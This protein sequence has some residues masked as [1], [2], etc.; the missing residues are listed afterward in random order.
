MVRT[1]LIRNRRILLSTMLGVAGGVVPRSS[2]FRHHV[3]RDAWTVAKRFGAGSVVNIERREIPF[4]VDAVI[5]G[6]VEDHQAMLIAALARGLSARTFFEIGTNRGRTSWTV[7]HNN[8]ELHVYTLDVPLGATSANV[9]LELGSD[10]HRFFRPGEAC[11]E[12]FRD[13][14]E[15]QRITQLWGDSATFDFSP[16]AGAIDLIYVDGGHSYAY[17]KSDT[18]NALEVL[19]PTGAI[20][21]DD[22]GSHPG[23]YE[24]VTELAPTLDKP[25][26]HVF[27]SRMAIY[28]RRDFVVRRP[29]DDHASLPG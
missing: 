9:A 11:G 8:P 14:P 3:L 18:K 21:W 5:K 20:V 26:Y 12:A 2:E 15:A 4:F 23:V 29:F 27:G 1:T 28:S 17:V 7:A 6:Y 25:V 10:D 19:S 24:F 13:T 22:Y 16:Y